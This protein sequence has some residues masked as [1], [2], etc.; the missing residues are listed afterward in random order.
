MKCDIV[1]AGVGGQGILSIATV[2]HLEDSLIEL[3]MKVPGVVFEGVWK[4]LFQVVLPY[5]LMATLPTQMLTGTLSLPS[6]L[7]GSGI[8]VLFTFFAF[9]LWK[10]GLTRYK[11]A[12]S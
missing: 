8:A 5:G 6:L 4:I 10:F 12:S 9:R 7:W 11:S 2:H 3:S 1:L